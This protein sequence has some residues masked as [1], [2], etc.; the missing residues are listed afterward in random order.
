MKH[1]PKGFFLLAGAALAVSLPAW[2][3]IP[4]PPSTTDR[5]TETRRTDRVYHDTRSTAEVYQT[6]VLGLASWTGPG[7]DDGGFTDRQVYNRTVTTPGMPQGE[8]EVRQA[9]LD[10]RGAAEAELE[11]TGG[12]GQIQYSSAASQL[13][14]TQRSD[15]RVDGTVS[16]S[17][18]LT[19]TSVGPGSI[20]YGDA[21]SGGNAFNVVAGSVE[22]SHIAVTQL[23]ISRTITDTTVHN[24]ALQVSASLFSSPI[25]LDLSGKGR[26]EAS[27]G[28]WQPHPARFYSQ[29]RALFDFYGNGFPVAM[30]WVGPNDGLLVQPKSDGSVDGSCLFGSASGFNHGYEQLATLDS[31][32]DGH[33]TGRELIGLSVWQDS[34]GN[35]RCDVGELQSLSKLGITEFNLRQK[36]FKSSFTRNGKQQ[37]M[38]DWWPTMFEV[39]K[40]QRSI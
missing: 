18:G 7:A 3:A 24:Y 21:D 26:L 9:Y 29:H 6:T 22:V 27:G 13:A 25:V 1:T 30:E 34:N 2:S 8:L 35:A 15:T 38:F 33:L 40:V 32:L 36:D 14:D 31:N 17:F 19:T 12:R 39:Q 37:A 11:S 10:A 5:H 16:S 28:E 4:E 23:D 20:F